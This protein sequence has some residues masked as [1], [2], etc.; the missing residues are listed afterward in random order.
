MIELRTMTC[1]DIPLGMRLK[2]QAGWNQTEDDWRRFLDLEP[3]GCFVALQAGR[4][5]GTV[6]T[7]VFG[8]VGW[9]AMVLVDEEARHGGI[10]TQLVE[11]ALEYLDTRGGGIE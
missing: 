4:P 11:H 5:L 9:I 10:G 8:P 1:Q 2:H 6:A 7:F 3:G